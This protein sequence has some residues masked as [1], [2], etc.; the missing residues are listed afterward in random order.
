MCSQDVLGHILLVSIAPRRRA[1]G[2]RVPSKRGMLASDRQ[3]LVVNASPAGLGNQLGPD[4]L[5]N[6]PGTLLPAQ[7][8]CQ[9]KRHASFLPFGVAHLVLKLTLRPEAAEV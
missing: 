1:G 5:M 4:C 9:N 8:D 3:T 6:F 7:S 2:P